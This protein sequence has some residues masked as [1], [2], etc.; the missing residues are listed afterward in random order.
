MLVIRLSRTGKKNAPSY[1]LVV[2]DKKRAVKGKYQE[3]L[4]YYNPISK[5]KIFQADKEK[6]EA[7]IKQGAQ[8][9]AT[10]LN[11]LCDHDILPK[12]MKIKIVHARKKVVE[13]EK[14]AKPAADAKAEAET[15][16]VPT[17][18]AVETPTESVGEETTTEETTEPVADAPAEEAAT[19]TTADITPAA[20]ESAPQE[21]AAETEEPAKK[22]TE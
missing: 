12:S 19:E 6:V 17:S 5:P 15:P 14:T 20:E 13:E 16:A 21:P 3:I 10:A 1:R 9:S 2:A 18:E 22:S 8:V 4:G 11:L 7:Y